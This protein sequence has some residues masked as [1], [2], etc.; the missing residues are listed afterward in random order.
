MIPGEEHFILLLI[1][2]EIGMA[3]G[4]GSN[5]N[6]TYLLFSQYVLKNHDLR[7]IN[8]IF[9]FAMGVGVYFSGS[10]MIKRIG[11][12]FVTY[13]NTTAFSAQFAAMATTLVS[14]VI[15]Y[16]V[17]TSQ[18]YFFA[19]MSLK[20]FHNNPEVI[21]MNHRLTKTIIILWLITPM[22]C[23]LCPILLAG[24]FHLI[25]TDT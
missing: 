1:L 23:I 4:H 11:M 14:S 21:I 20:W 13:T 12:N 25:A 9:A 18:A 2:T 6:S 24:A 19:L 10:R 16:P 22:I 8:V 15:G 17:S 7:L 3:I 5:S